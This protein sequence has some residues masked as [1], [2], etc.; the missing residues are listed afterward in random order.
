[1][2]QQSAPNE[3]TI[4][5]NFQDKDT[6]F[7]MSILKAGESCALVGIGS[8]GKSNLLRSL[9]RPEVKLEYL[10]EEAAFL[11]TVLLDP[12]KLIRL[13][14]NS[15]EIGGPSWPG[16]ELMLSG[17]HRA[18]WEAQSKGL[19]PVPANVNDS[20]VEKT[21]RRYQR[22]FSD[23][24]L[25][26]QTGIRQLED[27]IAGLMA[28]DKRWK[29]AFLF[30]EIEEFMAVLPAD[31]FQS[32]RGLR[33]DY[34]QRVSYVTTSRK[35]IQ[36]LVEHYAKT[37]W[38]ADARY[39]EVIEGFAELLYEHT[40]YVCLFDRENLYNAVERFIKRYNVASLT[41]GKKHQLIEALYFVTGGHIGLARR[42]F[43][44]VVGY[45]GDSTQRNYPADRL[46]NP[47]LR[48]NGVHEECGIIYD[49]LPPAEQEAIRQIALGNP[50]TSSMALD[51]LITKKLVF[52]DEVLSPKPQVAIPLLQ[53]YVATLDEP[54]RPQPPL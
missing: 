30:D 51:R 26:A 54:D 35:D 4:P 18:L 25:L 48:D 3:P 47:L 1:M 24:P 6:L 42:S 22:L 45:L 8:V 36:E 21:E 23:N 10:G 29:V 12:H 14:S 37:E 44:S 2:T 11:I 46:L 19:I 13:G 52:R 27:S 16:Y 50:V 41:E 33:D 40:H 15:R 17:L 43:L 34:K 31:F 39:K 5:T 9:H 53:R 28:L 7:V 49:S 20:L 32:L 38:S